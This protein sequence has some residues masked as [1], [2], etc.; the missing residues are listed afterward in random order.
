MA[1]FD[2]IKLAFRLGLIGW[3]LGL[4]SRFLLE[5]ARG[6]GWYELRIV[7]DLFLDWIGLFILSL[8]NFIIFG[9]ERKRMVNK[10]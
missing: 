2:T 10:C 8:G 4:S 3:A 7:P 6:M 5:Y 9:I 1:R